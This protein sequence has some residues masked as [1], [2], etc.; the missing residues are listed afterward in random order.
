MGMQS[1]PFI[2]GNL[3]LK[4]AEG[5]LLRTVQRLRDKWS[6]FKSELYIYWFWDSGQ[7]TYPS[8]LL[9]SS[10]NW[11]SW[12][13]FLIRSHKLIHV[14]TQESAC[15]ELVLATIQCYLKRCYI[16]GEQM[17]VPSHGICK[18]LIG[19]N[20]DASSF[21]KFKALWNCLGVAILFLNEVKCVYFQKSDYCD[22]TH[23]ITEGIMEVF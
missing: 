5:V 8:E 13:W 23:K 16:W 14:S 12:L 9:S 21:G 2:A 22:L 6:E 17:L 1:W 19:R 3:T 4:I 11:S 10:L 20:G 15:H 7:V 18:W